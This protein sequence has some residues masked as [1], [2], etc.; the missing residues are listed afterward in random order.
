MPVAEGETW[1]FILNGFISRNNIIA[2]T[3][4]M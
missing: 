2:V 1:L 4:N 3:E